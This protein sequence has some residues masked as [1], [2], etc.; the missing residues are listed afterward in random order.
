M[1]YTGRTVELYK[2]V[3]YMA[4][5]VYQ[6]MKNIARREQNLSCQKII[7]WLAKLNSQHELHL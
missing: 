4:L 1:L 3:Y 7:S 6:K 5:Y 2:L